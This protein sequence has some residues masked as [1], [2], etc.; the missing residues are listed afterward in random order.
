MVLLNRKERTILESFKSNS[1][2]EVSLVLSKC[3]MSK[4]Y[5]SRY[6]DR[7]IKKGILV[8]P[9]RGKLMFALPRFKESIEAKTAFE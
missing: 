1:P 8:S 6:R 4:E 5:L 7:L 9:T 2:V 3:N